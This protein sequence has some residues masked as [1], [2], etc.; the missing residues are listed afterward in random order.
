[1][2]KNH[3]VQQLHSVENQNI[4]DPKKMIPDIIANFIEKEVINSVEE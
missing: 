3:K 1:M 4:G 2:K